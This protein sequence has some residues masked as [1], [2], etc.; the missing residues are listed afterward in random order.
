[1]I[2]IDP[3]GPPAA[4]YSSALL[5]RN[6]RTSAAQNILLYLPGCCFR[7]PR[8]DRESFRDLEARH[9][10]TRKFI[11]LRFRNGGAV[12]EYD[13]RVCRFTPY[14]MRKPDNGDFLNRGMA[15]QNTFD[16]D[17]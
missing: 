7:K 11:Q 8:Y 2:G 1:M 10:F 5:F 16:F 13:E 4:V 3:S 6:R 14:F 15:Q 17:R 12:L 9:S